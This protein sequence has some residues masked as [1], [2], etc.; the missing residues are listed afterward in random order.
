MQTTDFTAVPGGL[1]F[2]AIGLSASVAA[3][4]PLPLDL[5]PFG[6]PGCTLLHDCALDFAA[7][8]T[9]LGATTAQHTLAVPS[10]PWCLGLTVYVQPFAPAPG[11]NPAGLVVGNGVAYTFANL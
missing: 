7:P 10:Q 11:A 4:L 5:A 8:T 9:A 3:G 2:L 1:A 6:L